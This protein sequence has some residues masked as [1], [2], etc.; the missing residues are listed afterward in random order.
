[1]AYCVVLD[2]HSPRLLFSLLVPVLALHSQSHP[3]YFAFSELRQL[4]SET[5]LEPA[6]QKKLGEVLNTPLVGD[7]AS[8]AG[9]QPARPT[10]QPLG[11]VLRAL[12]WNIERGQK[13]DLVR[14]ALSDPEGF[15]V[16][17]AKN[18]K[19]TPATLAEVREQVSLLKQADLLILNEVDIGMKR[20]DYHDVGRELAAALKMNYVFG[21]EFVEL[22]PVMLGVEKLQ[23]K[24]ADLAGR[25]QKELEADPEQLR[26][27]H[28]SAILSRYP[29]HDPRILRLPD[30][31]DWFADESKPVPVIEKSKRFASNRVF[32]E[33]L[34]S[35]RRR[36]GRIVIVAGL[37][38]PEAPGGR[39]TVAAAHL[40]NKCK[41]E[42]RRTQMDFLLDQ[43]K[44]VSGPVIVAGD[45]NTTGSDGAILSLPYILE[46]K[47]KDYRFWGKQL[48]N[49]AN[50]VNLFG[51]AALAKYVR[52]YTDPTVRDVPVFANNLEYHLFKDLRRYRF[53]DGGA[54]DFRGDPTHTVDGRGKTLANSNQRDAKGF[55]HTFALPRDYKGTV[56]RYKLDW[57]FIKPVGPPESKQAQQ[58][59]NF[60]P[61]F[62][63]TYQKVNEAPVERIS[64]H[65]P[66]TIDLPLSQL[67]GG[68]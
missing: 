9:V 60:A 20:S 52:K 25:L 51:T 38:I 27:L 48:W 12:F 23:L 36:G 59:R 14:L 29:I 55:A 1:M 56:G 16:E 7:Y 15:A 33:E 41:A 37:E 13:F 64:D 45:M 53:A 18:P 47:V 34:T 46:S 66:M 5:K 58:P 3:D 31:H 8:A 21:V 62:A 67:P 26:A 24:D 39:V 22:D 65:A 63:R 4:S 10:V 43:L 54:F 49:V 2:M 61:W 19:A 57:F 11:P 42:C 44:S 6:L 40:E 68:K 32:L 28:G 35:E 17:A 50:P 30:C